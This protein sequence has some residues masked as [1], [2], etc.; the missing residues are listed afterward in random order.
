MP[1]LNDIDGLTKAELDFLGYLAD[2]F[3]KYPDRD[4]ARTFGVAHAMRG[5]LGLATGEKA[6]VP[7][8]GPNDPKTLHITI[9][10][11]YE[12]KRMAASAS[13]G[14]GADPCILW[15]WDGVQLECIAWG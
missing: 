15:E 9:G 3:D 13:Q 12:V 4:T 8:R 6:F 2:C 5:R 11:S 10:S 1:K 7:R 14:A